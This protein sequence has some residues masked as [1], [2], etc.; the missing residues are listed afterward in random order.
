MCYNI[1]EN[2][3][4]VDMEEK[5]FLRLVSYIR[6]FSSA[7]LY[8]KISSNSDNAVFGLVENQSE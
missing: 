2:D 1:P 7:P 6:S 5:D 3:I 8:N 4:A